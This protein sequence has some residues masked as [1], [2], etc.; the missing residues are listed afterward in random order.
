M[1]F[2]IGFMLL[3]VSIQILLL[4]ME[5]KLEKVLCYLQIN[6]KTLKQIKKDKEIQ[7]IRKM[8]L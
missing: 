3:V 5:S 1:I 6:E 2:I 8:I 4:D 7:R